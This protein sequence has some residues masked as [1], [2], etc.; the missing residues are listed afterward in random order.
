MDPLRE[1]EIELLGAIEEPK[2]A[3]LQKLWRAK[4]VFTN[5]AIGFKLSPSSITSR[6]VTIKTAVNIDDVFDQPPKGFSEVAGYRGT[7]MKPIVRW[8]PG[9]NMIGDPTG[10]T[11]VVAKKGQQTIVMN[12]DTIDILGVGNYEEAFLAMVKNEWTSK[13][14]LRSKPSY[15]KIDGIFNINK[16]FELDEMG[17]ELKRLPKSMVESVGTW[18]PEIFPALVLKLK[19]PKITYQFFENG[20]VLFTGIKDPSDKDIPKKIFKEFFTEHGLNISRC[21]RTS[22]KGRIVAPKRG[23]NANNKKFKLADRYNFAGRWNALLPER[24][25]FY[26]R[27]GTNGA[28]RYYPW[29]IM[30]KN[31]QTGQVLNMGP[32]NLKGVAPKV[33]KAFKNANK[34]IPNSTRRLFESIGYPLDENSSPKSVVG[35]S[36]RRAPSWNATKPGFYV[37]PGPGQQPY[38]F[39]VPTG[40]AS[41]RKTVITTYTKA[42]RNIP[43]AVRNIFKIGNNVKTAGNVREHRVDIGLD[44]I[45]R[46][47][48]RQ[49]TRL[50]KPELIAIARNLDIAQVNSKMKPTNIIAWIH[51][52]A[53]P[54][55]HK[56]YS[57]FNVN[58][59]G[60]K[61]TFIGN[62]RVQKTAGAKRTARNWAT[63]PVSEQNKIAKSLLPSN[64]HANWNATA[65]AAKYKKLANYALSKAPLPPPSSAKSSSAASSSVSS[66]G[67]VM[68]E[69]ERTS[70]I[71]K[72]KNTLRNILGPNYFRNENAQNL[73]SRINALPSGSRGAP[74][75]VNIDKTLKNFVK[76]TLIKRRQE[77]IRSNYESKIKVPNWLPSNKKQAYKK[78]LLNLATTP[79]AKG[80]YPIQK[81]LKSAMTAW[82]NMHIPKSGHAAYEKENVVTGEIIKV[83]AWHPPKNVK[84]NIP[85][86]TS[87]PKPAK[88]SPKPKQ[89]KPKANARLKKNYALPMTENVEN[90]AN[91]IARLG[92]PISSS[93]KY[94]WNRLEKAG[95]SP[96]Y[97]NTWLN[98]VAKN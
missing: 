15:K 10:A 57:N 27:P 82:A 80:K 66:M 54:A 63:I 39:K 95:L 85:K 3:K 31:P 65:K 96:R 36:N 11:K 62:N 5:S 72:Y 93:N 44:G 33:L 91:A 17:S 52:K 40:L 49:A 48:N 68:A 20:T 42:G 94:S 25:G 69:L 4:R 76:Q 45:L 92:L 50:T 14:L 38:W 16:N 9:S 30:K 22:N 32:M 77:I 86:R 28:A 13:S 64:L 55:G 83:P 51:S 56:P 46:I 74:L 6:I 12:K 19:K 7:G 41:G 87:P 98:H 23:A 67:S 60:V 70:R 47:N 73:L 81:N 97:R 79:N 18:N 59:N 58:V 88:K 61:Y 75:K 78:T 35:H 37:R 29:R 26:I 90:M 8:I 21:I 2:I 1:I 53:L 43:A 89:T 34:P 24:P 71:N 84:I